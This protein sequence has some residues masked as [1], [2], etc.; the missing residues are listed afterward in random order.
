[1]ASDGVGSFRPRIQHPGPDGGPMRVPVFRPLAVG[2]VR[3]LGEPVAVV[4]AET[5]AQAEDAAEAIVLEIEERLTVVDCL[6]ATA[7]S[8]PRVWDEYPDNV[9]FV[10]EQGDRDAVEAA[11]QIGR[12][13]CRV[14]WCQYV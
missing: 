5:R 11:F 6:E 10:F 13:S 12:A 2:E 1:M 9:S 8:A 4:I 14:R 7:E 3:L